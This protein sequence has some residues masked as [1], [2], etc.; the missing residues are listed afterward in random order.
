M[1]AEHVFSPNLIS[2]IYGKLRKIVNQINFGMKICLRVSLDTEENGM[3]N[4]ENYE[5]FKK[6]NFQ[7]YTKIEIKFSNLHFS[8]IESQLFPPTIITNLKH[9]LKIILYKNM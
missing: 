1:D 4:Q 9:L 5:S 8:T 6:L 3:K 7:M 2:Q